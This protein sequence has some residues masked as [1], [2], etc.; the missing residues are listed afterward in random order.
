MDS[1]QEFYFNENSDDDSPE[2]DYES[3]APPT[4]K[5][6]GRVLDYWKE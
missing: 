4:I 1:P 3:L 6:R 2:F 5:N